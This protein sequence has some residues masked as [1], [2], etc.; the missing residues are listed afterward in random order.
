MILFGGKLPW[1]KIAEACETSL[2]QFCTTSSLVRAD[3]RCMTLLELI[4]DGE[5]HS[6]MSSLSLLALQEDR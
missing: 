6:F 5:E 1:I 4:T 3:R 2:S